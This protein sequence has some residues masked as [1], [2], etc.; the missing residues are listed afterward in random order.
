MQSV[1]RRTF[2]VDLQEVTMKTFSPEQLKLLE[3]PL[4]RDVVKERKQGGRNVSYVEAWHAIAEANRIFGYDGWSS[5]TL[6]LK[7]VNERGRPIGDKGDPGWAVSYIAKVRISL[8]APQPVP[9]R[10][11]VREGVGTGHGIDR[12]LGQAHESAIKE[13]E[14]DAFKRAIR[15]FGNPFGL[16]LYDKTQA[17]VADHAEQ[18]AVDP[19]SRRRYIEDTTRRIKE[20]SDPDRDSIYRWWHSDPEKLARRDFDIDQGTIDQ[21]RQMIQQKAPP[22]ARN[23]P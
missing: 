11:I 23:A 14:S 13:A 1:E 6:D 8:D 18:P 19:A 4:L 12:D 5:E 2:A 9:G 15:T 16:A 7:C 10:P 22:A 20:W 17:N 3:A 21:W